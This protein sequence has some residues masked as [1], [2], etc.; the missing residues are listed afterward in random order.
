M[1]VFDYV[2]ECG[3]KEL[4]VFAFRHTDDRKCPVCGGKMRKLPA[5]P[6]TVFNGSGFTPIFYP[7]S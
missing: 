7:K 4:D 3:H 5:A 2:C 1:P 6:T